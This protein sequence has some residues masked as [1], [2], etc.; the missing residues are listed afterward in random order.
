MKRLNDDIEEWH[1]GYWD[2]DFDWSVHDWQNA[3]CGD[4][5]YMVRVGEGNTGV[6]AA[7]RF[8]SDPS[9]GDGWAKKGREIY[10]MQMEFEA[11]FHAE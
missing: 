8:T 1:N 5:F 11:V 2:S 4:R 9:K 6:F 3:Q 7:G 10:Y